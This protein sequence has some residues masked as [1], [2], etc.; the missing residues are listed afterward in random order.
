MTDSAR[1]TGNAAAVNAAYYVKLLVCL[2]KRKRLTN[3]ELECFKT[4]I[5]VDI[6]V[7]DRDFT[8]ALVQSYAGNRA[9]SSAYRKNKVSYRTLISASFLCV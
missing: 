6:A 3:D 9:F 1:L 4:E 2:C 5:I 7:V 8:C